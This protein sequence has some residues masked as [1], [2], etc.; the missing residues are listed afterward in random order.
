ML[1]SPGVN[2]YIKFNRFFLF[3][4]Y[5]KFR[6][7]GHYLCQTCVKNIIQNS[8]KTELSPV[9]IFDSEVNVIRSLSD[10][11]DIPVIFLEALHMALD[12]HKIAVI[13]YLLS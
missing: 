5:V 3:Q 8:R 12:G 11:Y 7:S 1:P 6:S 4:V 9:T 13:T 10:D 2:I